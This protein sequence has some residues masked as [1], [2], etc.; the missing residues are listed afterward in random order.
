M[1]KHYL[2]TVQ[3][4]F[5]SIKCGEKTFELRS[6][7]DRSFSVGDRVVLQEY[8]KKTEEYTSQEIEVEITYVLS[9]RVGLDDNY[10]I[11]SF[12]KI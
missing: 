3:P 9:H 5:D 4:F 10:C 1:R 12:V 8:V 7:I 6:T 2:K 11:F